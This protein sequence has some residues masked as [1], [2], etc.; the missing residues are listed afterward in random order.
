MESL[1]LILIVNIFVISIIAQIL[2]IIT[3]ICLKKNKALG[4]YEKYF[5]RF[6][7]CFLSLIFLVILFPVII[8]L[9]FLVLFNLGSPAFFV[10]ERPGLNE[11][12]FNLYKFRTMTTET[13]KAHNLLPDDKRLTKFGIWLRN[14]SLDELPELFNIIKGEM[15]FIGPRPLLVAY[16]DRYTEEQHHRHD[17]RPGLT[18]LAQVNGRNS[19]SWEEKF[20]YDIQYVNN[21]TFFCDVNI[22]MQT[23]K[24]AVFRHEGINFSEAND[25]AEFMGTSA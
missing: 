24:K 6:F 18:G 10:Q 23:I 22:L 21:I 9:Y 2:D 5:K 19:I 17:V 12:I 3:G 13:D 15:S 1:F 14:T 20:K 7:D 16:L 4:I 8:M 25:N 11:K